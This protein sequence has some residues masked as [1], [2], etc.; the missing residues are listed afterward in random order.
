MLWKKPAFQDQ[1][2]VVVGR[3]RVTR[4]RPIFHE[5]GLELTVSYDPEIVDREHVIEAMQTAG[6]FVGLGDYR[7]KFG[8]FEVVWFTPD[9]PK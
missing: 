9:P 7:P 2:M 8:R 4:T 5:W 6:R 3:A 1:R